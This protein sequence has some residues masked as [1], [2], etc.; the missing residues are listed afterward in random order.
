[1]E[2]HTQSDPREFPPYEFTVERGKIREFA[3]AI[4]D[5]NPLHH[6]VEAARAAGYPDLVAPLTFATCI[7]LWGG[8]D[9][10]ELV[11]RLGMD[12][13]RVLHGEQAYEYRA[14]ICAGDTIRAR[15]RVRKETE[16]EG[17]HGVLRIVELE[18]T[19]TNQHGQDVLV[20]VATI[21][22]RR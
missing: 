15:S 17:S 20:G 4:G 8:P 11:R 9:F 3:R 2:A 18:T 14:P 10:E 13:V 1:M 19:Y 6:D 16:R 12:P 21:I 5:P 7:D 22:E